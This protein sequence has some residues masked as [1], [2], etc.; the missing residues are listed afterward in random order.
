[1]AKMEAKDGNHHQHSTFGVFP[2]W[3]ICLVANM[4]FR[5]APDAWSRAA[6]A[7]ASCYAKR[8]LFPK[9]FILNDAKAKLL[10]WLIAEILEYMKHL[11][12]R[13]STLEFLHQENTKHW[14][15]D[16]GQTAAGGSLA[17]PAHWNVASRHRE[18]KEIQINIQVQS[19][20]AG[21]TEK[22]KQIKVTINLKH[23]AFF[24]K[25]SWGFFRAEFFFS[26]AQKKPGL[27]SATN[28]LLCT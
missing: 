23:H 5:R 24:A 26:S 20:T 4:Y 18:D 28:S 7:L 3:H 22:R 9:G 14:A 25:S 27:L 19:W 15:K 13:V 10:T 16:Q 17:L 2:W 6:N 8:R 11:E 21:E 12:E 1:M